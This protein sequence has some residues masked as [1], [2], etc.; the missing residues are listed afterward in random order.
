MARV[1][2]DSALLARVGLEDIF[3]QYNEGMT[4]FWKDIAPISTSTTQSYIQFL[5]EGDF[6]MAPVVGENSPISDDDIFYG[7]LK[8][9][10]PLKRG[11]GFSISTE[12]QE[13]DQYGKLTNIIPKIKLAF[14]KTREQAAADRINNATST[15]GTYV[16]PDGAALASTAHTADG[17][18][19]SNL[20]TAAFGPTA[21]ETMVQNMILT[22]SHRGDPDPQMGPYDLMIHP[23]QNFLAER[24]LFSAGQQGTANNDENRIG[25]RIRKLISSPYFTS[26]T[27]FALRNADKRQQP[28]AVLE[29]RALKVR[30]EEDID[31][32]IMKYRLTEMYAFY[33]RGW[34]G[35]HH[36]TG[37]GA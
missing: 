14:N 17:A 35:Y 8:T 25:K 15:A 5:Q 29:R 6:M 21:L 10:T 4:S 32:D 12:A 2:A 13:T 16:N 24:V 26:S 33:E 20:M 36:S 31:L 30:T 18:N 27:F 22:E 3:A 37:A 34:R 28:F 9:V 23:S 19:Q 7:N 11:L 1:I